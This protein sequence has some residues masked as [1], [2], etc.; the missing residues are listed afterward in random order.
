VEILPQ[1][2][3]DFFLRQSVRQTLDEHE[4]LGE[5][6]RLKGMQELKG[7]LTPLGFFELPHL[8]D[9]ERPPRL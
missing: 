7:G 9:C 6:R 8:N 5:F 4:S 3:F 1:P 2:T